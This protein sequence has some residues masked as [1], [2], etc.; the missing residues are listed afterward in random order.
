[1]PTRLL[2]LLENRAKSGD[3]AVLQLTFR[4]MSLGKCPKIDP[5][6]GVSFNSETKEHPQISNPSFRKREGE[7][8]FL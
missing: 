6:T 5:A 3:M 2:G 7:N 1:L 8:V 4:N